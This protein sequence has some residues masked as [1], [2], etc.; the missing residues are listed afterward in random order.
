MITGFQY[1][2][3][4]DANIY[5]PLLKKT[6]LKLHNWIWSINI[7]RLTIELNIVNL[8]VVYNTKI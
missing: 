5:N 8:Y 7:T 4:N 6:N 2:K 3:N 1:M